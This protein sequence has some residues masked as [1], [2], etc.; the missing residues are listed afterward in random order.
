[1][2]QESAVVVTLDGKGFVCG[3]PLV[4]I[5]DIVGSIFGIDTGMIDFL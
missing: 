2:N 4:L 1:M 3:W 5:K